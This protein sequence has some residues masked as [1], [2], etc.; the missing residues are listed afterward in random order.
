MKMDWCAVRT[1][2]LLHAGRGRAEVGLQR[3]Q[4]EVHHRTFDKGETRPEDR[5]H[6]HPGFVAL[7]TGKRAS[8]SLRPGF[9]TG[10]CRA[11]GERHDGIIARSLPMPPMQRLNPLSH[12]ADAYSRIFYSRIKGELEEAL[13]PHFEG[14]VIACPSLLIGDREARGQPARTGEK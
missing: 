4:G 8:L 9:V 6:E 5:G 1:L 13:A 12:K 14:L 7:R 11:V 2:R 3:G 10:L